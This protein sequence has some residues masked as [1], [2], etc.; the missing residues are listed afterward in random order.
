MSKSFTDRNLSYVADAGDSIAWF[1]QGDRLAN[2]GNYTDALTCFE[3]VL[4]IRPDYAPAWVFRGVV[5][6]HLERYEEALQ[7]CEKALLLQPKDSESW[8][9][10]GVALH[11]LGHY[12]DAYA[13]YDRAL[14]VRR[15]S[16]WQSVINRL[17]KVWKSLK[18]SPAHWLS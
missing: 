1:N 18:N 12:K 2:I 7:S 13:S 3:K 6:I 8:I 4:D 14:G 9:F 16:L 17:R 10:R 15:Q 11:R 5:L